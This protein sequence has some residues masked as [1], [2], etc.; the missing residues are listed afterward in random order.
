MDMESFKKQAMAIGGMASSG[1][2]IELSEEQ[3][4][5]LAS[6]KV[7]QTYDITVKAKLSS[8][9]QDEDGMRGTFEIAGED[10]E[11]GEE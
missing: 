2:E 5:K 10:D 7:G 6:W 9:T 1:Q 3:V 4:P 8:V 11:E